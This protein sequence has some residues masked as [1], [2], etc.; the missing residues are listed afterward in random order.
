MIVTIQDVRDAGYCASGARR[1]FES[2][3]ID[4]RGFMENGVEAET[5]LATEDA[6]A[7]RVVELKIAREAANG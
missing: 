1:W 6:M 5:L 7:N 2:Y 3:G 4:F